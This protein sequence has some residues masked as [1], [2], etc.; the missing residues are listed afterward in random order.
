MPWPFCGLGHFVQTEIEGRI[1]GRSRQQPRAQAVE[2]AQQ[3]WETG[4]WRPSHYDAQPS[5]IPLGLGGGKTQHST[6]CRP[7]WLLRLRSTLPVYTLEPLEPSAALPESAWPT[8]SQRTLPPLPV[9]VVFGD[10][11]IFSGSHSSLARLPNMHDFRYASQQ[12]KPTRPMHGSTRLKRQ[13]VKPPSC[14]C[15]VRHAGALISLPESDKLST[16]GVSTRLL[17]ATDK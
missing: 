7:R 11:P 6:A 3:F 2:Y 8:R 14:K 1:L 16:H 4:I 10:W 17:S 12:R 15:Q 9:E 13:V 5:W